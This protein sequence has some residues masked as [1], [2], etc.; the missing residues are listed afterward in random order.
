M[1][2]EE[3]Q[4]AEVGI[5]DALKAAWDAVEAE[6]T[7]DEQTEAEEAE[8]PADTSEEAGGGSDEAQASEADSETEEATQDEESEETESTATVEPPSDWPQD[9]QDKFAKL[10]SDE[11]RQLLIDQYKSMQADYTRKTQEIS[12]VRKAIEPIKEQLDLNGISE[13]Q[14]IRQMVAADRKLNESP[15]EGIQFLMQ[16]YGI[17]ADDLSGQSE[18]DEFSDPQVSQLKQEVNQLKQQLQQRDQ[19]QQQASEQEIQQQVQSFANETDESGNL[20]HPDFEH[21]K[22]AMAGLIQTGYAKSLADAYEQA[23]WADPQIREKL[24]AE[25]QRQASQ[26]TEAQR[27][28]KAKKAKQARTPASTG[29]T[30]QPKEAEQDLRTE[31]E[32]QLDNFQ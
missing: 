30:E 8:E 25:Q 5:D 12:D 16:K 14:Y 17:S 23:K 1:G 20:K 9:W 2:T 21:L 3:T 29:T 24:L 19:Q 7:G 4:Q 11:G 18:D 15:V 10:D 26:E 6:D 31:L 28:E 13:G 22:P 27:K 32:K